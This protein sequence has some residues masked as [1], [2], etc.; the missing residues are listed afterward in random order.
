MSETSNRARREICE[1]HTRPVTVTACSSSAAN[2]FAPTK[3]RENQGLDVEFQQAK[4]ISMRKHPEFNEKWLQQRISADPTLLGLGDL[5]L[6]DAEKVQAH[7][8]RLDL[9]LTD[10]E[11][12]TRY[13]VEIQLGAT[14]EGSLDG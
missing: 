4:P 7:A 14:D 12:L 11:T 5:I 2:A 6:K 3:T 13:E 9:L 1:H 10:V 8:G